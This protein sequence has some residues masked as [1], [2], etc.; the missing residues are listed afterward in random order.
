MEILGG[1]KL[2]YTLLYRLRECFS[3][4]SCLILIS[5]LLVW[6]VVLVGVAVGRVHLVDGDR[7]LV[8]MLLLREHVHMTSVVDRGLSPKKGGCVK[9]TPFSHMIPHKKP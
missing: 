4:A 7:V 5:L 6:R 3:S 1:A 9:F 2:L 8:H